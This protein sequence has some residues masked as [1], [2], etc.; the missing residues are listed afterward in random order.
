MYISGGSI[1]YRSITEARRIVVVAHAPGAH[2][3]PAPL[4][5]RFC[6]DERPHRTR[7]TGSLYLRRHRL[8][9]QGAPRHGA[10]AASPARESFPRPRP[11][12]ARRP[13]LAPEARHVR[14]GRIVLLTL[15]SFFGNNPNSLPRRD[16][17][18]DQFLGRSS[19][20]DSGLSVS[21]GGS[22]PRVRGWRWGN[23]WPGPSAVVTPTTDPH[24]NSL[25][26]VRRLRH[27]E[28]QPDAE[29]ANR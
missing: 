6:L 25:P 17:A 14:S 11:V 7:S 20:P 19:V 2:V 4:L 18:P 15:R 22:V 5:V 16:N 9:R 8:H 27:A 21:G 26:D 28:P 1:A 3:R 12:A 10:D 13:L 29:P 24:A 23:R